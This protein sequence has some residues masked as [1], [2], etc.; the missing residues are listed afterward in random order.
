MS[1]PDDIPIC[2]VLVQPEVAEAKWPGQNP[3]LP[4]HCD[5]SGYRGSIAL[6]LVLG[7]FKLAWQWWEELVEIEPVIVQAAQD[8]LIRK[9]FAPIDGPQSVLAWSE[10]ADNT[11]RPKTQR[12]DSGD[13]WVIEESPQS[14]IDL[15]RVAC[16]E[17]GHVLGLP[18][19][20]ANASALMRPS[21]SLAIRRPTARDADRLVAL[22][23]KR[24]I[25]GLPPPTPTP[26]PTLG[27]IE[28][29]MDRKKVYVPPG[30]TVES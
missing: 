18:H 14:G 24:R 28:F 25:P 17:I 5:L 20:A 29:D 10:L 2:G 4:W 27:R 8:A 9:H 13:K 19:D 7:A 15:A 1:A 23:Y 30:W 12:Y 3:R 11:N 16:H 21:Y 26:T 6:D 22:G